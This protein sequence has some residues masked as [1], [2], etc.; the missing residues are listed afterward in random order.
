[1]C[2]IAGILDPQH[3]LDLDL[4]V[5][6]MT[7]SLLHRGPDDSGV[8]VDRTAGVALGHR[9]LSI[10]DLSPLGKQP[11]AS[12]SGRYLITYNGE[13]Y[14]H[15][16][17]RRELEAR[18]IHLRGSSDTEAIVAGADAWGPRGMVERLDGIFAWALWDREARKL[19]LAR[20]RLGVKPL[21]Y[22]QIGGALLWGSELKAIRAG[23]AERPALDPQALAQYLELGYVS[24][25][26][27]IYQGVH[28]LPPGQLL[29]AGEDGVSVE[30]YWSLAAEAKKRI[31]DPFDASD[32]ELEQRF[33]EL[34][35]S[36][37]RSQMMSDV[38]LGAFLSGGIDSSLVV[39]MMAAEA[40]RRVQTFSIGVADQ[41]F[42]ESRHARRV[43][44]HLGT[45]HVEHIVS[46]EDAMSV[47]PSLP[48]YYDEPFSDSSQIPTLIV[49]RLARS[50]VTVSLSGDGGDELFSGYNRYLW[51][52]RIVPWARA[53]PPALRRLGAAL[54]VDAS[55]SR[56][57]FAARARDTLADT[58]GARL[59]DDKMR[60]VALVL[61]EQDPERMYDRLR[62]ASMAQ[63]LL[64]DGL[65]SRAPLEGSRAPVAIDEFLE[66]TSWMMLHDQLGYLPD[67]ILVKVDRASMAVSLE[68]R[69]PLLD[70][71]IVDFAW[72][73]PRRLKI[74]N[75]VSKK[76]L[77]K[78]LARYV[79]THLVDRPKSGFGVP[80]ETWLRGGLRGWASDLLRP[81]SVERHGVLDPAAVDQ[82]W[83][84]VQDG[85]PG[86]GA[87]VWTVLML[88]AW[89][90]K[91]A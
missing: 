10:L 60:K 82:L 23:L 22:G 84:R 2:G 7:T 35:R 45:D 4:L 19:Y 91:W 21:Y 70:N 77:R 33:D 66:F 65:R 62:A 43:A 69:V 46:A 5:G 50:R 76:I 67:D 24:G 55:Q 17:L 42:D 14:N 68:A 72:Q 85:Q 37:V 47:V 88:E 12:P 83:R 87:K 56:S 58:L 86:T 38:P 52:P 34:L 61:S 74:T 54:L 20:D 40:G 25:A 59:L 49:S 16:D 39:S 8:Y 28:R 57:S 13:V 6:R 78:V 89:L 63:P 9:R 80:I 15:V 29:V 18:G 90:E 53:L 75:G 11:M 3:R 27:T 79:P 36:V 32:A 30:T 51:L 26:H 81:A 44:E 41:S 48:T 31:S 64:R 1:M 71:R 73:L